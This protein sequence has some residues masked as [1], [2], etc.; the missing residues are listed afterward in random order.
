MSISEEE[1]ELA[2][3]ALRDITGKCERAI[4]GIYGD[5]PAKWNHE[6]P[7]ELEDALTQR[8]NTSK[9]LESR[10]KDLQATRTNQMSLSEHDVALLLSILDERARDVEAQHERELEAGPEVGNFDYVQILADKA[11]A[12]RGLAARI[13]QP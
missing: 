4:D 3:G 6:F 1:T 10:I 11:N 8:I 7:Q 5:D 12:L 13:Q 9:D 2:A